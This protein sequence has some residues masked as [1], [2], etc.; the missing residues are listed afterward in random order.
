MLHLMEC[1]ASSLADSTHLQSTIQLLKNTS[2]LIDNFRDIRP[3]IDISERLD[4]LA[5]VY[6]WFMNWEK[7]VK[8]D[9]SLQKKI[10]DVISNKSRYMF[11]YNWL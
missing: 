10:P 4:T 2:A 1:Y 7:E 8:A 6:N 9:D 11:P 5:N 3:I